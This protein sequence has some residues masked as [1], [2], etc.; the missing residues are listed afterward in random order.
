MLWKKPMSRINLSSPAITRVRKLLTD[1]P[2]QLAPQHPP[3]QP[4]TQRRIL[5]HPEENHSHSQRCEARLHD[6]DRLER[7][8]MDKRMA[9]LDNL[10][11]PPH[12]PHKNPTDRLSHLGRDA[13]GWHPQ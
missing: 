1:H 4:S 2:S 11:R 12:L 6:G 8:Q 5:P 3:L 9:H 10:S 13:N 7:R